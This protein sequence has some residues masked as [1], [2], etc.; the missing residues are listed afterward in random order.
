[1]ADFYQVLGLERSA[2]DDDIK[3]AYR[4]LALKFHPEQQ[5]ARLPPAQTDT[6]QESR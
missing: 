1:M 4:K 6:G 2:N 5:H 3:Q